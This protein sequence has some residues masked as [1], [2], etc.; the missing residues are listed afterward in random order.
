M[1]IL[2]ENPPMMGSSS[3]ILPPS[4]ATS[5][6]TARSSPGRVRTIT[7]RRA[8]IALAVV[9]PAK[10][11]KSARAAGAN[12]AGVLRRGLGPLYG[13]GAPPIHGEHT[14]TV[15]VALMRATRVLLPP[16]R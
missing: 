14:S 11:S 16:R 4:R 5:R 1:G 9:V 2:A 6:S 8:P 15:T 10:T 7:S 13:E 12:R 3:P